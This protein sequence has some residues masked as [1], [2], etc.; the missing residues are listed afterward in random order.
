VSPGLDAIGGLRKSQRDRAAYSWPATC[1][2]SPSSLVLNKGDPMARIAFLMADDFEDSEYRVPF[3]GL[4][5]AGHRV[6]VLG[7]KAGQSVKGKEGKETVKI[8]DAVS[9][10]RV[11]EFDA[12]VI[13]GGYS[14]DKLRLDEAA[15]RFVRDFD[16]TGK[17]LAAVCHGPQ[18]LI[19]AG[20]VKG[21]SMTSWPSVRIDL[22]N[23][24]ARWEDREVSTDGALITSR[25]PDDLPAFTEAILRQ[26]A[27]PVDA[28]G[29][30]P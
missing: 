28:R 13:P 16:Q 17:P 14:P 7:A 19:S 4:S 10:H 11:D 12:L 29:A 25:K 24:G 18:L 8:D 30:H 3:D 26:L 23:A 1:K 6:V 22:E 5:K 9:N 27:Q 20:I 15:V 2:S 21:R